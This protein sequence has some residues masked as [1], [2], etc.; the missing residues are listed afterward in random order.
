MSRGSTNQGFDQRIADWLEDDPDDAPDIVL[1]TVLAAFP[2]IPQRPAVRAP[3]RLP[4][5]FINRA[6]AAVLS[7]IVLVAGAGVLLRGLGGS[8][9]GGPLASASP[10]PSPSNS[11]TAR[12][13]ASSSPVPTA[14]PTLSPN[15]DGAIAPG[16][17][18]VAGFA[19]PFTVTLPAGWVQQQ[20]FSAHQFSIR[21]DTT[22]LALIV[23]R[24]VYPDPCHTEQA[25]TRIGA[26]V[27]DLVAALSSMTGFRVERLRD[28][29]VGGATGK[30]FTLA[31]SVDLQAAGCSNTDVL[32][33]GRDGDDAPIFETPGSADP[34][35]AVDVSGTTVLIGGPASVVDAISFGEPGA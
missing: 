12:P 35:W 8:G 26:G 27:N 20:G 18:H 23:V 30:A 25:P 32:W 9:P 34:V 5:M 4:V 6:A 19:T 21:N 33:I 10:A 24:D 2:S 16:T 29:T 15:G 11:A 31:N 3:W 28:A 7:I 17:Y 1:E 13:S 14:L 22:F